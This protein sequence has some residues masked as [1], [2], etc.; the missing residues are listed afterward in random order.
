MLHKLFALDRSRK[1]L[2]LGPVLDRPAQPP[3]EKEH[4]IRLTIST[5]A[6]SWSQGRSETGSPLHNKDSAAMVAD[7][8]GAVSPQTLILMP[9]VVRGVACAA[10]IRLGFFQPAKLA[11]ANA[12]DMDFGGR[13]STKKQ[14]LVASA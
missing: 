6:R 13:I 11:T 12:F 5:S 1:C 10:C 14:S 7:D 3:K 8:I 4:E 9:A 2:I